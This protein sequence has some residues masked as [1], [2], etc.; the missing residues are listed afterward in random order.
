MQ[1]ILNAGLIYYAA[2]GAWPGDISGLQPTYLPSNMVSPWKGV[3]YNVYSSGSNMYVS[4]AMPTTT[5]TSINIAKTITGT[6]PLS[7]TATSSS[8]TSASTCTA[9]A[10]CYV[11][12]TVTIPAE[13]ISGAQAI[14]FAGL[15][16]S[17]ACVPAPTCPA[18]YTAQVFAVPV[19]VNAFYTAPDGTSSPC[20]AEDTSGCLMTY[21]QLG[22]FTAYA[23]EENSSAY[24][25]SKP[26]VCDLTTADVP[27]YKT[28]QKTDEVDSGNYWRVCLAV[29]TSSGDVS[30]PGTGSMDN[31][32]GQLTGTIM[33]MTRCMPDGENYGS[34]FTVWMPNS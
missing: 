12:A 21:V 3:P 16:H 27:C 14:N 6:L 19:S 18:N 13:S 26:L 9:G 22:G 29:T 4:V 2:N 25:A 30:I 33:V 5:N 15:Y 32:W 1:Q 11:V 10:T 31:P 8:A 20:T 24:P 28:Y 17:G 7:F 23:S 34:D